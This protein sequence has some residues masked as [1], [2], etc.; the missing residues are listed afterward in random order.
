MRIPNMDPARTSGSVW[1]ASF[2]LLRAI[3]NA[4]TK[5]KDITIRLFVR[6]DIMIQIEKAMAA[7]PEGIPPLRG[8]PL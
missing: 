8:V 7:W 2:I 3:K 5:D 4:M 6:K 1:I